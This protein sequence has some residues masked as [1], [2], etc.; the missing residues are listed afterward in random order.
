M[1]GSNHLLLID[2]TG[3]HAHAWQGGKL[4]GRVSFSPDNEGRSRFAA[5]LAGHPDDGFSL[6]GDSADDSYIQETIPFLLYRDRRA[7]LARKLEQH[8]PG[9]TL[10]IATSLGYEKA[11]RKNERILFSAQ[12]Q[13]GSFEPWLG[14]L[15]AQDSCLAGIYN[16]A[17][18][19][20]T[21]VHRLGLGQTPCLLFD[22]LGER[23]RASLV[24]EGHT[25]FSRK[26]GLA[27]QGGALGPWIEA[28]AERLQR[29]LLGQ[30]IL[31]LGIDLPLL[32]LAP[33]ET[34]PFASLRDI[35]P[36]TPQQLATQLGIELSEQLPADQSIF[37]HLLARFPPEHQFASP[38]LLRRHDLRQL[39]RRLLQVG[40]TLLLASLPFA[41]FQ[42]WQGQQARQAGELARQQAVRLEA[43]TQAARTPLPAS[44]RERDTL[45]Q[46]VRD[47]ARWQSHENTPDAVLDWLAQQLQDLPAI[48]LSQIEWHKLASTPGKQPAED[49]SVLLLQ[50]RIVAPPAAE[51]L[52]GPSRTNPLERLLGKIQ[53]L[54]GGSI[55]VLHSPTMGTRTGSSDF[56]LEIRWKATP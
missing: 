37:L 31:R 55:R 1:S 44:L 51:P 11:A 12:L 4:T 48:A 6:F 34:P 27:P 19:G 41:G 21:L 53:A 25:R 17:Q 2:G 23:P 16:R 18:L 33:E 38:E 26:L 22:C 36:L 10:R 32:L 28:E 3:L 24:A 47:Q 56:A 13:P 15:Q 8:F 29:Y 49:E 40:M 35:R 7:L 50:G 5:Y 45:Q 46:L 52:S 30:G 9:T 20:S 43:R 42:W 14:L 54:P 39:E